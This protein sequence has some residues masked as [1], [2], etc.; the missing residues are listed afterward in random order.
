MSFVWCW[1]HVLGEAERSCRA[2]T[3]LR[4]TCVIYIISTHACTGER[5]ATA[6]TLARARGNGDHPRVLPIWPKRSFPLPIAWPTTG[7]AR[8]RFR[9]HEPRRCCLT[10]R[11][12]RWRTSQVHVAEY[13]LFV[14]RWAI[15]R[16]AQIA[17]RPGEMNLLVSLGDALVKHCV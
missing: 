14:A 13:S 11:H 17:G 8:Y 4:G 15:G 10:P 3:A 16:T 5:T 9:L 7:R 12:D 1:V 6:A 2:Q